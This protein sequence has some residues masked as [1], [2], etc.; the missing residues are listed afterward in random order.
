M[1]FK[2]AALVF[3]L[4]FMLYSLMGMSNRFKYVEMSNSDTTVI[5]DT[6]PKKTTRTAKKSFLNTVLYGT[7]SFYAFKFEGR[8]TATG[9]TFEQKKMTAACNAL[10]LGTWIKVTNLKNGKWVIVKTNDRL[11]KKTT[12]LVD[13]SM[14][15]TKRLGFKDAG[16][17]RVKVEV[18][19]ENAVDG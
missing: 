8:R 13:L 2:N 15:A 7:A 5:E 18:L 11:H 14:A 17:T 4:I 10:P 16:L 9:E 3:G 19:P 6:T 1:S 12:R